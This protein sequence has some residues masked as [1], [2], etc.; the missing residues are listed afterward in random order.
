MLRGVWEWGG[1]VVGDAGAIKFVQTDHEWAFS[2]PEAAADALKGGAD[3]ALGGGYDKDVGARSFAALLNATRMT[4][5]LVTTADIDRALARILRVRV[6]LGQLDD[7]S[8]V[9]GHAAKALN[10]YSAVPMTVVNSAEHRELAR[11]AA[12]QGVV[13]LTNK[14]TTGSVHPSES[15]GNHAP[16]TAPPFPTLPLNAQRL[17]ALGSSA[18]A[19]VGPNAMLKAVGNYASVTDVYVTALQGLRAALPAPVTAY[20]PGIVG[21]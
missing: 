19:V 8:G 12:R 9:K 4:P 16:E 14:N 7:T 2:Q 11:E 6:L 13:L 10:P 5:P 20:A 18:V 21:R 1:Y 15:T 17:I 3:L